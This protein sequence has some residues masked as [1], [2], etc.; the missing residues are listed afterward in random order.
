MHAHRVRAV[1]ALGALLLAVPAAHGDSGARRTTS[2]ELVAGLVHEVWE[3]PGSTAPVHVA[4]RTA[5]AAVRLQLVQASDTAIG[6]LETT[7]S[8]C[9]RTPGCQ[10]AVNGDFFTPDGAPVGAVVIG[11]RM[12]RSP[13]P[14]HEQLS[15]EP[16]RATQQGLGEAGWAG[17]VERSDGGHPLPLDG[18]NVPLAAGQLV[19]YTAQHGAATPACS[20]VEVRLAEQAGPVAVLD[21]PAPVVVTG[22]G[23]GSSP[24]PPG[25]AVLAGEGASAAALTDLLTTAQGSPE[26]ARLAVGVSVAAPTRYNVGAHPVLLRHGQSQPYDGADPMLAGPHPRTLVA[27]DAQGTVWLVAV[28]GRRRGGPGLTAGE[29]VALVRR[30]GATD[31]AMLDGGGSTTFAVRGVLRNAPSDGAERPV[32]NAVLLV[33]EP[34]AVDPQSAPAPAA[35]PDVQAVAVHVT[36]A[37]A[38]PVTAPPSA[39]AVALPVAAEPAAEVEEEP[40]G[41]SPAPAAVAAG[42]PGTAGELLPRPRDPWPERPALA[43]PAGPGPAAPAP[44]MPYG[45]L[46]AAVLCLLTALAGWLRVVVV[47]RPA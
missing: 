12:L 9:R 11:G 43:A 17:L 6:G 44:G 30:L 36:P 21:R 16:L 27:W 25:T 4:R 47:H 38:A 33:S 15:L 19:L 26:A 8:M 40:D 37:P 31:A 13:R 39:P 23:S 41:T 46:T 28:D 29:V 35:V 42:L 22:E 45:P 24:L 2:T 10:V 3:V 20:C 5:G 7:T 1:A 18:V 14:D 32:A 34:A